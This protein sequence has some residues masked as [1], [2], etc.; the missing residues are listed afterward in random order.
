[1]A[2]FSAKKVFKNRQ[3]I[4]DALYQIKSLD[5][6]EQPN[7]YGALV[8][9]LIDGGVS[10]EEIKKVVGELREKGEIS[11]FDEENLL[12]LIK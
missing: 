3:Q 10:A 1:M 7:V 8:K 11:E 12:M 6:R 2:L 9:E 5:Y 4:K